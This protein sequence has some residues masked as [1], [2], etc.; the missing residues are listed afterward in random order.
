MSYLLNIGTAVPPDSLSQEEFFD[1]YSKVISDKSAIR[2]L[3]AI[4][5]RSNISKRHCIDRDILSLYNL[6]LQEKLSKYHYEAL[7]L[8]E[9]AVKN[10]PAYESNKNQI[11]DIIFISCTGMQAPGVEIDL[12]EKLKLSRS[13]RRY[14]INFM[15]CYASI[16]GLR[17]AHEI[18]AKPNRCVLLVSIELCT[19]HFQKNHSDDYILSNSL[20]S[21]GSASAIISSSDNNSIFQIKDFESRLIPKSKDEMSW[22]ISPTGFLMTLSSD[23]PQTIKQSLIDKNLFDLSPQDCEWAI[24][25]GGKQIVDGVAN[26]LELSN[27]N[28]EH[29]RS[30]LNEF[31]NMSSATILFVIKALSAKNSHTSDKVIACAFGPGLTLESMLLNYV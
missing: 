29:S 11:T 14:N 3:K 31:G 7:N 19:L 15:G 24:H 13:I 26:I 5:Q 18:C 4:T 28:V 16:T 12:I 25:P 1:I 21:D 17:L 2:K 9:K 20:F 27:D 6:P 10:N 22:K 8:A 30:I 23:V